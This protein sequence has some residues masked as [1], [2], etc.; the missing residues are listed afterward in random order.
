[1]NKWRIGGLIVGIG[2]M[3]LVVVSI[4]HWVDG[5][6]ATQLAGNPPAGQYTMPSPTATSTR[7]ARAAVRESCLKGDIR[8]TSENFTKDKVETINPE[9]CLLAPKVKVGLVQY[10]D[11]RGKPIGKP[12]RPGQTAGLTTTIPTQVKCLEETCEVKFVLCPNGHGPPPGSWD[13]S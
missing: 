2:I 4:I 8:Y 11:H 7:V 1:M 9:E 3:M 5:P 10:L 13:C 6:P 12:R